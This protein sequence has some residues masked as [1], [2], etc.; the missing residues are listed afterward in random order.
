MG[1]FNFLSKK[2]TPRNTPKKISKLNNNPTTWIDAQ[3]EDNPRKKENILLIAESD[4]QNDFIELHFI[5]NHLIDL[6]YKQRNDWDDALPKCIECCWKDIE[7]FPLFKDS[8]LKS[9]L[10]NQDGTIPRIPSFQRLAIIY[11][12]KGDTKK[13][14][15]ICEKAIDYGLTEKTKGG[16]NGRLD[17]LKKKL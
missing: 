13:A 4:N 2:K 6:Y 5:Y 14:I 8:Y 10:H 1:I 17:R 3:Y 7:I 9:E 12:K 15:S 16:F 11:E